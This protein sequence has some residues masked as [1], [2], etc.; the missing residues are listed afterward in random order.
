M[1]AIV[2]RI[3]GTIAVLIPLDDESIRVTVPVSLLPSGCKEGEIL[4]IAIERDTKA[5]GVAKER[6]TSLIERVKKRK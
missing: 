3:E 1:K 5:T 6:V 2:D 4:I